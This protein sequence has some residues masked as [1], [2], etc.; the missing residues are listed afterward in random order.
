MKKQINENEGL[1]IANVRQ[2]V[3]K[4]NDLRIGN[5]VG[6]NFVEDEIYAIRSFDEEHVSLENN[7]S[8]HYI[9]YDEVEPVEITPFMLEK[10]GFYIVSDNEYK[11]KFDILEYGR[12]DYILVKHKLCSSSVRFEGSSLFN[13]KYVHQLQNLYFSLTGRELTVA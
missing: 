1:I 6:Y 7:I 10:V 12:F 5:L 8:F 3:I 13:I 4:P 9:G 2:S 11:T